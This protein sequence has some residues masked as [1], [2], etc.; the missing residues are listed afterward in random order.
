MSCAWAASLDAAQSAW[1]GRRR[2]GA[3]IGHHRPRQAVW[4]LWL[5]PGHGPAASRRLGLQPQARRADLTPR[6]AEGACASAEARAVV[7]ERRLVCAAASGAG[8]LGVGLR[9]RGRTAPGTG[10][11]CAC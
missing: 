9:L 7:A 5:P 3:D 6:G 8:E 4:A 11:S 2:G 1:D 10:A